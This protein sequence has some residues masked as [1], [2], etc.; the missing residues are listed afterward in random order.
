VDDEEML[1]HVGQKLLTHLGYDAVACTSSLDALE[2]FRAAPQRFDL[3][4]HFI[5]PAPVH[6]GVDNV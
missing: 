3:D 2:T 5:N 6:Y 4:V 1:A